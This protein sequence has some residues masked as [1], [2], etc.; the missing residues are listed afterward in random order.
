[1]LAGPILYVSILFPLLLFTSRQVLFTADLKSFS[2]HGLDTPPESLAIVKQVE[3]DAAK[4]I[5]LPTPPM[6]PSP[7]PLKRKRGESVVEISAANTATQEESSGAVS[8][9]ERVKARRRVRPT[10]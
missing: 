7:L 2:T 10:Q 9:A 8:L 4:I 1:M 5:I 6:T 3:G